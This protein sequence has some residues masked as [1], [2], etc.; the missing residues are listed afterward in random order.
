M[1][2]PQ[3]FRRTHIPRADGRQRPLAIAALEDKLEGATVLVLNAIYE[4]DFPEF[5]YPVSVLLRASWRTSLEDSVAA[6]PCLP[7][8]S[9]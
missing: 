4:E 7:I 1:Y 5:S 6:L 8:S 3:P 2:R 9:S